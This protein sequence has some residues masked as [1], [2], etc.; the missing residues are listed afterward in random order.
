MTTINEY[1]DIL[2]III[3]IIIIMMILIEKLHINW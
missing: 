1:I 2:A 3:I